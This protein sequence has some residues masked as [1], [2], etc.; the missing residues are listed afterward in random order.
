MSCNSL[1]LVFNLFLYDVDSSSSFLYLPVGGASDGV[2]RSPKVKITSCS[3]HWIG[4]C[5]VLLEDDSFVS[6]VVLVLLL[7]L[8]GRVFLDLHDFFFLFFCAIQT[9]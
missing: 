5:S 3:S 7:L 1:D 6:R 2:V 9:S 4:F 8:R